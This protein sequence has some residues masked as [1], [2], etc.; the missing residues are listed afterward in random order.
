[1]PMESQVHSCSPQNISGASQQ[2]SIVT[3]S[4]TNEVN[5]DL[6]LHLEKQLKE[7]RKG[8]IQLT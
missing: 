4:L 6:F 7:N 2:N 1:M 5:G 3:F 8:T